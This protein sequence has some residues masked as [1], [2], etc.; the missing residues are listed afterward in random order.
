MRGRQRA[1]EGGWAG[2]EEA[3]CHS[4]P[5]AGSQGAGLS[6]LGEGQT[7]GQLLPPPRHDQGAQLNYPRNMKLQRF[8][9]AV[10]GGDRE[11]EGKDRQAEAQ[12]ERHCSRKQPHKLRKKHTPPPPKPQ[13]ARRKREGGFPAYQIGLTGSN[14]EQ[15]PQCGP[16]STKMG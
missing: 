5:S 10:L 7:H 11:A 6:E 8:I 4:S 12:W 14:I 13:S 16:I 9:S 1:G 15:T 2:E 3:S